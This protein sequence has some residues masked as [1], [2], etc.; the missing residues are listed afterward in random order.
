MEGRK[1]RNGAELGASHG[2]PRLL[3]VEVRPGSSPGA[4]STGA[5]GPSGRQDWEP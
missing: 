2:A 5:S 4:P 1:R 3:G